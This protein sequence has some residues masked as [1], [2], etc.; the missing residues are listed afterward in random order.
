MPATD[1]PIWNREEGREGE[2]LSGGG[3][4][5]AL[6]GGRDGD[7]F[8]RC[9]FDPKPPLGQ[10]V[11]GLLGSVPVQTQNLGDQ[12]PLAAV[13]LGE[14]IKETSKETSNCKLAGPGSSSCH[15]RLVFQ[16]L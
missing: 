8:F 5:Q 15:G 11:E 6:E 10:P 13:S 7:N 4:E 2:E 14:G 9:N 3:T 16:W 12:L 1:K